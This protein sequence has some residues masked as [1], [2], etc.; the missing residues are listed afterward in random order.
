M[1][2]HTYYCYHAYRKYYINVESSSNISLLVNA[3]QSNFVHQAHQGTDAPLHWLPA[4]A[5]EPL[6]AGALA[7][8][9]TPADLLNVARQSFN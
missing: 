9:A 6:A 4:A 3:R 2:I 8:P 1:H 7:E 5:T